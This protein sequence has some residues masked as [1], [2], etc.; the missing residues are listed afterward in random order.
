MNRRIVSFTTLAFCSCLFLSGLVPAA[1][2]QE[3]GAPGEKFQKIAQVL[4]LS[5]QQRSQLQPIIE[6]EAPKVKSITQDPNLSGKEKEKQLKA[7][8]GQT[9]SL[10]KSILN[11]TQY[12]QWEQIRKDEI[13]QMKKGELMTAV[14]TS[15]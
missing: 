14:G 6:A 2:S 8:H 12:K 15:L 5:P 11:P 13:D 10:V 4:N 3:P 1:K 7:I 9:D